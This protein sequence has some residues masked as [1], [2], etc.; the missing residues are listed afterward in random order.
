MAPSLSMANLP[1][2]SKEVI[3]SISI[4]MT[5]FKNMTEQEISGTNAE[6]KLL[7][8]LKIDHIHVI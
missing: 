3:S 6:R 8:H 2:T 4:S 5:D 7:E 1:L